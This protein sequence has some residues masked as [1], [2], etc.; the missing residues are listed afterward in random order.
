MERLT[1]APSPSC[2]LVPAPQQY[3]FPS[4]PMAH[5]CLYR[6]DTALAFRYR[7]SAVAS[8]NTAPSNHGAVAATGC[9]PALSPNVN[10]VLIVPSAADVAVSAESDACGAEAN[11]VMPKATAAP[12]TTL[13][14]RSVTR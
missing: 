13:P 5:R 9:S 2:P 3:A 1:E 4:T 12:P 14:Y 10:V 6:P 11:V 7:Q 8:K